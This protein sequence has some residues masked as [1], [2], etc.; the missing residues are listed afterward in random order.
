[1][2]GNRD[3]KSSLIGKRFLP[4]RQENMFSM[5]LKVIGRKVDVDVLIAI[6]DVAERYGSRFVH[7]TTGQQIELPLVKGEDAEKAIKE[8]GGLGLHGGSSGRKIR[9][10]VECQGDP[11]CKFGPIDCQ[12][13]AGKID[14]VYFGK[15][16]PKKLKTALTGRP[17]AC[18]R[19]QD[20][21]IDVMGTASPAIDGGPLPV[22]REQCKGQ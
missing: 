12:G 2:A 9:A 11:A 1:M 4:P 6:A 5:R 13:I 18:A 21:D 7:S 3:N 8:L 17:S 14:E 20:N 22:M 16:V 10:I 19:P 15:S